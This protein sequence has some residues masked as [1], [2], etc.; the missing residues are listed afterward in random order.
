MPLNCGHRPAYW[1][2]RRKYKR[3]VI[4]GGIILTGGNLRTRRKICLSATFSTINPTWTD[5]GVKAGLRVE[6][7]VKPLQ[8]WHGLRR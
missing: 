6:R 8:A 2:S 4:S 5:R 1:S 7:P 3:M